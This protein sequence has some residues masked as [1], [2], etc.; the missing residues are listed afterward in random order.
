MH[1]TEQNTI[2][3]TGY[4][5]IALGDFSVQADGA[6]I[7][8]ESFITSIYVLGS[9]GF[10]AGN[11]DA[12]F[13][14]EF[15]DYNLGPP[16][17][18]P[19]EDCYSFDVPIAV[20]PQGNLHN[21]LLKLVLR[22]L[23]GSENPA[24]LRLTYGDISAEFEIFGTEAFSDLAVFEQ[25]LINV[26]PTGVPLEILLCSKQF[27]A[28]DALG[29]PFFLE[30]IALLEE[31]DC[32]FEVLDTQVTPPD[33]GQN[34]GSIAL[35][36]SEDTGP[37]QIDYTLPDGT[38]VSETIP[39]QNGGVTIEN[40][41]AA[42]YI[43]TIT[44]TEGCE[45][46]LSNLTVPTAAGCCD[47]L[48][49][50]YMSFNP[51]ACGVNDGSIDMQGVGGSGEYEF[52]ID[53]GEIWFT[54][55]LF[56]NLP[57]G[58]Y[59]LAIRTIQD[60][61]FALAETAILTTPEGIVVTDVS[62][63][64]VSCFGDE[65]AQITVTVD[66]ATAGL[67]YS[68]DAGITYQSE[69][70]F[71]GLAA[72]I[73]EL[74][75]SSGDDCTIE[76]GQILIEAP[77]ELELID[78]VDNDVNC[79]GNGEGSIE[80][81]ASAGEGVSLQYS[82]DGG[83]TFTDNSVFLGL[84]PAVYQIAVRNLAGCLVTGEATINFNG[85]DL[86]EFDVSFQEN[87]GCGEQ[88]GFI[89]FTAL[90]GVPPYQY[91]IDGGL[92]YQTQPL[93]ENLGGGFYE[94]YIKDQ[95]DCIGTYEAGV[96]SFASSESP[97]VSDVQYFN[98]SC[99]GGDDGVISIVAAGGS[100]ILE[101]SVDGGDTY[102]ASNTIDGLT[103]GL[104]EILVR[105]DAGCTVTFENEILLLDPD[106]LSNITIEITQLLDCESNSATVEVFTV[107]GT[108]LLEY[109]VDGGETYSF[110]NSF[111]DLDAGIYNVVVKDA[112]DCSLDYEENPVI[113]EE[114]T[115]FLG[116]DVLALD[117]TSCAEPDGQI[118]ITATG[119]VD[120]LEYSI[121]NGMTFTEENVFSG[122]SS[123][124]YQILVQDGLGCE[125]AYTETVTL[126]QP[127]DIAITDVQT[128]PLVCSGDGTGQVT[129]FASG[130]AEPLEYSL[131]GEDWQSNNQFTDLQAGS[132]TVWVR[133]DLAC[134]IHTD[135]FVSLTEPLPV[136][137][138][139]VIATDLSCPE[140]NDGTITVFASGG[141]GALQYSIDG[142]INFSSSTVFTDLP[143][144]AYSVLVADDSDCT[145][146]L[147]VATEVLEAE[148]P[149]INVS[150]TNANDCESNNGSIEIEVVDGLEPLTYS[151]DNG[152]NYSSDPFFA[153]LGGGVYQ[154]L[155]RDAELCV[156][157]YGNVELFQGAEINF[158]AE[159]AV[160]D[161]DCTGLGGSISIQV[162]GGAEPY[163]YSIDNGS[164]FQ[165][166]GLFENLGEGDYLIQVADSANCTANYSEVIS[167]VAP[168]SFEILDVL[169]AP[170][171]C[172]GALGSIQIST[173][174]ADLSYSVDGTNFQ[175]E[176][177]FEDLPAGSYTVVVQNQDGSCAQEYLDNPV[178]IEPSGD[179][180]SISGVAFI[181]ENGNEQY[182]VGEPLIEGALV[183]IIA[184]DGTLTVLETD[185]LGAYEL[186]GVEPGDYIVSINPD[187]VAENLIP[188]TA[189]SETV[190]V[191]D[192]TGAEVDFGFAE[193]IPNTLEL[194]DDLVNVD[195]GET[196]EIDVLAND[197]I[198]D[199]QI[200]DWTETANGT[201]ELTEDGTLIF[202][203]A[204]GFTG[205]L[206]IQYS[207]QNSAGEQ[208]I[209]TLTINVGPNAIDDYFITQPNTPVTFNPLTNDLGV[210]LSVVDFTI[211]DGGELILGDDGE[212][213]FVPIDGFEGSVTFIYTIEDANGNTSTAIGTVEITFDI[214][215][216]P[217]AMDDTYNTFQGVSISL[218]VLE[219][220]SGVSIAIE[221]LV[222][223]VNAI[224]LI[225]GEMILFTP[226]DGYIGDITFTYTIVDAA[227]QTDTAI[228]TV[229]VEA[230]DSL[231]VDAI[232]DFEETDN[233]SPIVID[234][235]L[236]DIGA[237]IYISS[238]TQ[239][240]FGGEVILGDDGLIFT[241]D[242]NFV[243]QAVFQ[244]S[245]SDQE[246]NMDT[247]TVTIT[248]FSSD[249]PDAVDDF[250]TTTVNTPI[251][252]DL[253]ENDTGFAIVIEEVSLPIPSGGTIL[254]DD[255]TVT[256]IP[257]QGFTGLVVFTYSILNQDGLSDTATVTVNV[258]LEAN[259]P[260]CVDTLSF[261]T[262]PLSTVPVCFDYCEPEGQPSTIVDVQTTFNCSI[263]VTSDLCFNY[264]PLPQ[265]F[266]MDSVY[267]T[268]CDNQ[269]PQECSVST[270]FVFTLGPDQEVVL[271]VDDTFEI[272]AN[273]SMQ[274]DPLSNDE[275]EQLFLLEFTEPGEGASVTQQG[276]QLQVS[277]DPD[278]LGQVQF[279]YQ[280]EDFCGSISQATITLDII[281]PVEDPFEA[282]PDVVNTITNTPINI[283]VLD[284]DTGEGLMITGVTQ[285]EV[286][287]TVMIVGDDIVFT[288]DDDF[289]GLVEFEYTITDEN[290][291][292]ANATVTVLV[293]DPPE[294][295]CDTS[296]YL[297]ALCTVP[298]QPE[299]IC[300]DWCT[301]EGDSIEVVEVTALY[302]CSINL[303]DHPPE[304]FGY[305]ALPGSAGLTNELTVV[306]CDNNEVCDT[307]YVEVY[308]GCFP[309]LALDDFVLLEEE[310]IMIDV[311][312][313]DSD[314]CYSIDTLTTLAITQPLNG[315]IEPD[316]AG[317]FNYTPNEGFIG[318]DSYTYQ[319]CNPCI[320]LSCDTAT[321]T[322]TV[323]DVT[324]PEEIIAVLDVITT[325]YE[326][327][328]TIEVLINDSG[329]G[330]SIDSFT[331]PINGTVSLSPDGSALVYTPNLGF[332]GGDFFFYTIIDEEGNTSTAAVTVEVL[333][334]GAPNQPPSINGDVFE[335]EPN[336]IVTLPVL[337]N[338]S[339][340]EGGEISIL[341]VIGPDNG[342]TVTFNEDSTELIFTPDPDF[343][344][345]VEFEYVACDD[346][347]P[348]AC[349]TATVVISVGTEVSNN[350]PVATI[351][352]AT[353]TNMDEF[354][355][356]GVCG[357]DLDIDGDQLS[358]SILVPSAIGSIEQDPTDDSGCTFIYTPNEF[359][360]G[361]QDV[362]S[363]LLCDNGIP[364]LCDSTF[365]TVNYTFIPEEIS[366]EP[367]AATTNFEE[368]ITIHV[369]ANDIGEGL[370][371]I[372]IAQPENGTVAFNEDSTAIIYT[373][374]PGFDGDDLFFYTIMDADGNT[375]ATVVTITVLP[376]DQE[377]LP[378]LANNDSFEFEEY[379][380]LITLD[381]LGNDTDPEGGLLT[382]TEVIGPTEG[383]TVTISEDGT[384]L[385]FAP[386]SG[387][388]GNISFDY[389]VCDEEG[390]CDTATVAIA[391]GGMEP[392]NSAPIGIEDNFDM[393]PT[394]DF[395][396]IDVCA[397]DSDPDGDDLSVSVLGPP[398]FGIVT[399]DE[400]D[401]SGC[402]M[403]YTLLDPDADTD[404]FSYLLCDNGEP[405]LCDTV[406]VIITIY[407]GTGEVELNPDVVQTP[408]ETSVTIDVLLND[409]ADFPLT[410]T[411]FTNPENGTVAFGEG[412]TV[413]IYTPNDGFSGSDFFFYDA[414]DAEANCAST[415]VSVSVLPEDAIN[416]PPIANNDLVLTDPGEAVLISVL[417]ND[418]DPENQLLTISYHTDPEFGVVT[419]NEDS[420]ALI[421]TPN[422][423]VDMV[424]DSFSYVICDPLGLCDTANVFIAI[425][426]DPSNSYP[427]AENDEATTDINVPVIINI[428]ENDSD[429]DV[430]QLLTITIVA[431]PA[432]GTVEIINDTL[433]NQECLVEYTPNEGFVGE[434]Y[435]VY[436]L[437]DNGVPELC[438]TAFVT[439]TMVQD[440]VP[441]PQIDAEPDIAVTSVND[442][443]LIDVLANDEGQN[444]TITD[445][446]N[447]PNG[448]VIFTVDG[449]GLIYTPVPGFIGTDY[450]EYVIC[451]DIGQCDTALVAVVVQ[452]ESITNLPPTGISDAYC[453]EDDQPNII[454]V[455]AND[456]D[457]FG[458]DELTLDSFTQGA[459]G[460]LTQD[461]ETLLY[462]PIEGG[463]ECD[464]FE[465]VVCDNGTP[466]LCDTVMVEYCILNCDDQNNPPYALEDYA[467]VTNCEPTTISVLDNDEDPDG[468]NLVISFITSPAMGE[469]V[470]LNGQSI[471]TPDSGYVGL[472]YFVYTVCDEGIP[473]YCVNGAVFLTVE[474]CEPEDTI[475]ADTLV[476]AIDDNFMAVTG[477]VLTMPILSND[478]LSHEQ[479]LLEIITDPIAGNSAMVVGNEIQYVAAL[480]FEGPDSLQYLVCIEDICDSAWVY[481]TV[482]PPEEPE[483]NCD[484]LLIANGFSPNG[485]GIQDYFVIPDL[486]DCYPANE[487]RIYNRWG[488]EVYNAVG[489][490]D[491]IQWDGTWQESGDPLPDGTY[492]YLLVLDPAN[493][494][495]EPR[496]GY[497]ELRR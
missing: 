491:A 198:D 486:Y 75:V 103:S 150:I 481:I 176:S 24:S 239:P 327:P 137:V 37:F 451:D 225:E 424:E 104:Y 280:I 289:T 44:D 448:T 341:D 281:D 60:D 48:S 159:P 217:V 9:A 337:D 431:E 147:T 392:I 302:N 428:C 108:G 130:G 218:D 399:A 405:Q 71:A 23:Q 325:P 322:I 467:T 342:G 85:A 350:S 296:A 285:P 291:Q 13:F 128:T 119:G 334:D 361:A 168:A 276:A 90:G 362:F 303:D 30:S 380:E 297:T 279:D 315:T 223:P 16:F 181:D 393:L 29:Q 299:V 83:E 450:F 476:V 10:T 356:I 185:E 51:S 133:D 110:D 62:V 40:L 497:I 93:F 222:P 121:D 61:C 157:N 269:N 212:F 248:V 423:G 151:I 372:E 80:I 275:G 440:S 407:Q 143:P 78:I 240:A 360:D 242:S 365:V 465:Y 25:T 8:E 421:Y 47:D 65:D 394:E 422:D 135:E 161:P 144:G 105:D 117:V 191:G 308:V 433:Q 146:D 376:D 447:P 300:F 446:T 455:L 485:D 155:V 22:D 411:G 390:L 255:G 257:E 49:L 283:S 45:L 209:A 355:V 284:N 249:A 56:N 348:P 129:V 216:P 406:A 483:V 206:T 4:L 373:P 307:A 247:A 374:N 479:T 166:T 474:E 496:D 260:P 145:S 32:C 388:V 369:L 258:V 477:E 246:G 316:A 232:N 343:I 306:A 311:L 387:Y 398:A 313:N 20:D 331:D 50:T 262:T 177:L 381:V 204:E 136:T 186:I 152:E 95:N 28:N 338:D 397:N 66:G 39:F 5:P 148:T 320:D 489:Y 163:A 82:I 184:P 490:G 245:I 41:P 164:S 237:G 79:V 167:L 141:S 328:V 107:G 46:V 170:F 251:N 6:N 480:G 58:S 112:N 436:I 404:G 55:G 264:T 72:G 419:Y 67:Q 98:P 293:E 173:S 286:G 319:V 318:T 252:L 231:V 396:I 118:I 445:F 292:T 386:D 162:D 219:N 197:L 268:I 96:L 441:Q 439:I 122:L 228:V 132:Y 214:P 379:E 488:V 401:P 412:G 462:T 201:F 418:S 402:T 91:S 193:D 367:D 385:I 432:N 493:E 172:A 391:L 18:Q 352:E 410:I 469:A 202:T 125:A 408:Y 165:D 371:I 395:I 1:P 416:M 277:P 353:L 35:L 351:D 174:A 187:S 290:G 430:G 363:Y 278:Y 36:L 208:G 74:F 64:P 138:A 426:T 229:T 263:S 215:T 305:T 106:Q 53:G 42:N 190:S 314:P 236:N 154:L 100:G 220:D 336:E 478:T 33:C 207:A 101:Y 273:Q 111:I 492:F 99:F 134:L 127:D 287:G 453:F 368:S 19:M 57:P 265:F 38:P 271:A 266:G 267:V 253:I 70:V 457:S 400:S 15:L 323:L 454:D 224:T 471:Y 464:V 344:G 92:V 226:E 288:P 324:P 414:C 444:L 2:F 203:P 68:I 484:S 466:V 256:F 382:I 250:Y 158:T 156:Y 301:L 403:I 298:V 200:I 88:D 482:G 205:S 364:V 442:P 7:E 192:G 94:L 12:Y 317:R 438:D 153:E 81:Y 332:S 463:T 123:G 272:P 241:P 183:S 131:N 89:E 452:P 233:N 211:P 435:L 458:G 178:V 420:T 312:A 120:P 188:I 413:L 73:Y 124:E 270:V 195:F 26:D 494:A 326:T 335:V 171:D 63:S 11:I 116:V 210:D 230:D 27:N 179:C 377:N 54:A 472:D 333:E 235:L 52:S 3:W 109:S 76:Y 259:L 17:I 102:I 238:F 126:G 254:N 199:L 349:D 84:D 77:T 487:L 310:S 142:G 429:P 370:T 339:D 295:V 359:I 194:V 415:I 31:D 470:H 437:C 115:E 383:G 21:Y 282:V 456:L 221:T 357:N 473:P 409:N 196:V 97:L 495:L 234:A 321:V 294:P 274:I 59:P 113:I 358:V 34:N 169:V 425:G 139:E 149:I 475:P 346:D 140:S 378:P 309:P 189:V 461:G 354:V 243:G 304:C 384:N 213:T 69:N 160:V 182:D 468:D 366:A 347:D 87:S 443:V 14:G 227:G 345:E 434:D 417:D 389:E 330:I 427:N 375:D 261:C 329:E 43:I 114:P 86:V 340:P 175:N 460:T 244:Y 459:F 449:N 180:G